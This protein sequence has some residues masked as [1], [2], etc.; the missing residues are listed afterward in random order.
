[1]KTRLVFFACLQLAVCQFAYADTS[2]TNYAVSSDHFAGGGVLSMTSADYKAEES[3]VD[4]TTKDNLTSTNYKVDGKIGISG[5]HNVVLFNSVT[6]GDF[7][8]Y[9]TDE[10][11]S[12]AVSAQDPDSDSLQYQAKQDGTTKAGPQ[13]SSTLG[14]ALSASDRGRR[15]LKFEIIDPDGTVSKPQSMYVYRRPVK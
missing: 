12:F 5:Q 3:T 9:F 15:A 11:T 8:K 13:S 2:S 10:S 7:A 4:W 14:W 6:P 1:M